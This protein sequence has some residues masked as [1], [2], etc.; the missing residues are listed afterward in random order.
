ME[1]F[2]IAFRNTSRQAR[3]TGLLAGAIAFGT[4]IIILLGGFTS[5]LTENVKEN[6]AQS[7]AG[8]IYITASEVTSGGLEVA[9]V[10]DDS[11]I[12]DAIDDSGI[13]YISVSHRTNFT[14]SISLGSRKTDQ[15]IAGIKVDEEQLLLDS[16]VIQSGSLEA[17]V[18]D[19]H[20]IILSEQVAH[21]IRAAAGD[22]I[23]IRLTTQTGQNNLGEFTIAAILPDE[24]AFGSARAYTHLEYTNELVNMPPD[25]SE[26]IN[27]TLTDMDDTATAS[28][29]LIAEIEKTVEIMDSAEQ[30]EALMNDD[31]ATGAMIDAMSES[32]GIDTEETET[33]T[34]MMPGMSGG[35]IGGM[36]GGSIVR[37]ELPPGTVT[38]RLN[39][40]DDY[41]GSISQLVSTLNYISYGVFAILLL[42][43]MVGITNTYRMM[44][45]ER[46]K[47]I[48]TMRAL[49]VHKNQIRNIFLYEAGITAFTGAA[50]GLV[51]SA[52]IML[53]TGLIPFESTGN[54]TMLLRSGHI[55]YTVNPVTVFSLFIVVVLFSM[56]AASNPAGK[57]AKIAPAQAL[58]TTN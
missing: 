30:V 5:G 58:R 46:I 10:T 4:M 54:M 9:R 44:M 51:T 42:I 40:I 22:G 25:A 55:G 21:K 28:A 35:G 6:T 7:M 8:H 27:I 43:T 26:T 41:T 32:V 19:K 18:N 57:A 29:M 47:E 37:S 1:I 16:L 14:G 23:L 33:N 48:G 31:G 15:E 13:E 20:G 56:I 12:I 52:V 45:L 50:A 2:K 38:L 53:I 11:V 39:T 24:G 3:R 34:R 49:G 17:F 36:F